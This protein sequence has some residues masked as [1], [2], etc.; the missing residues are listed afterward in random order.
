MHSVLAVEKRS[1]GSPDRHLICAIHLAMAMENRSCCAEIAPLLYRPVEDWSSL[2]AYNPLL[3]ERTSA[4]LDAAYGRARG[5][6]RRN[7]EASR[8]RR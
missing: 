4:R 8:L 7:D 6:I 3:V 2:L 1:W 5:P